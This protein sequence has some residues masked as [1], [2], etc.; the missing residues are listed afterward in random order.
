MLNLR[1]LT[2]IL[3]QLKIPFFTAADGVEAVEQFQKHRPAL[4]L[5]DINMPRVSR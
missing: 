2:R 4:V 1:I 5:L 3:A